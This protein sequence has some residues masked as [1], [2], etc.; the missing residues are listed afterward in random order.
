MRI[1]IEKLSN[2]KIPPDELIQHEDTD[3]GLKYISNSR[4]LY[5]VIDKPLFMLFVI[6]YGIVFDEVETHCDMD[7]YPR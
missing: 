1:R 6:K 3:F 2:W 7:Y 5:D 4:N